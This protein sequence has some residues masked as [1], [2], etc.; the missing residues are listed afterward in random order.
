[1]HTT[2][3]VSDA[4]TPTSSG[5]GHRL[6]EVWGVVCMSLVG[7]PFILGSWQ[8]SSPRRKR[9][10]ESSPHDSNW[11]LAKKSGIATTW[12]ENNV[13]SRRLWLAQKP[14]R[15]RKS[16]VYHPRSHPNN[17]IALSR[18]GRVRVWDHL[19]T[20]GHKRTSSNLLSGTWS[21]RGHFAHLQNKR[22]I[23]RDKNDVVTSLRNV[24]SVIVRA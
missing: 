14:S 10:T 23:A 24:D 1:M 9:R 12:K 15:R 20:K 5:R 3:C 16:P 19:H 21:I 2:S 4:N 13:W 22:Y 8:W 18:R 6:P 7:I 11:W 17:Q